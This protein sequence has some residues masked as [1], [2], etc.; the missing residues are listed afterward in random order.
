MN[1]RLLA[2]TP[3]A[4]SL[5]FL[6]ACSGTDADSRYLNEVWATLTG[7]SQPATATAIEEPLSTDNQFADR[8]VVLDSGGGWVTGKQIAQIAQIP[9]GPS[10]KARRAA[11]VHELGTPYRQLPPTGQSDIVYEYRISSPN[12]PNTRLVV[13]FK[14]DG[15]YTGFGYRFGYSGYD[16]NTY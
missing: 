13:G 1:L 5:G 6:H 9:A 16:D 12:D 15:T 7:S 4:L 2:F 8:P 14:A 11:A 10:T 3:F